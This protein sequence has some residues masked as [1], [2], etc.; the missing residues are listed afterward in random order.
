MSFIGASVGTGVGS[1]AGNVLG[2]GEDIIGDRLAEETDTLEEETIPVARAVADE[3]G[4][5]LYID[6]EDQDQLLWRTMFQ[7]VP[8]RRKDPAGHRYHQRRVAAGFR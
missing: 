1:S 4:E 5:K 6:H 8:S 2:L 7:Q 3:C